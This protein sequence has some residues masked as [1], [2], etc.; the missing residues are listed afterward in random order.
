MLCIETKDL[1]KKYASTLAVDGVDLQIESGQV[2]G[3]LGPNGAGKSTVIK[4]LTTLIS[5]SNGKISVLGIDSAKHPLEIRK[6]IGVVLQQPSYEPT[7]SAEKSLEKYGMMWNIDKKIRK[8][9]TEELLSAFGLEE[10]RKKKMDDLSIGQRRRV[11]VA[12]EF[13]HDMELLFLDEPTVGLDPAAR[14]KLLDFLREQV[15]N[16]GLTIFYTTHVLSEAEYLC[17]NIAIINNGKIM[18]VDSPS[19]LKNR[20]GHEK[21][22]KIHI[23]K[24]SEEL[25]SKLSKIPECQ[26]KLEPEP[27][28]IIN[29]TKSEI[30]LMNILQILNETET[31]INDLSAIPTNLEEIFLKVVGDSN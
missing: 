16:S 10:I 7:L 8:K 27:T 6:K 29:S 3:F 22:I 19:E 30:I 21:T 13:M 17:D 24:V 18:A 26:I 12:R 2:F 23:S 1:R 9:R 28:V 20:F 11:Q 25:K 14:R 31:K 5:P 4:L 15:K